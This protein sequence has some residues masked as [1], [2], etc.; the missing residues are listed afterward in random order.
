MGDN[1]TAAARGYAAVAWNPANLALPGN[2]GWSLS[3]AAVRGIAGIDPVTLADLKEYEGELVPSSVRTQWLNAI[4][5]EG[6]EAGSSGFDASWFALQVG[7]FAL[8]FSSSGRAQTELSPGVAELFLFGNAD[9]NGTARDLDL[10][11]SSMDI[12]AYSTGAASYAYPFVLGDGSTR[13]AVGITAKY[14]VGHFMAHGQESTGRATADPLAMQLRFPV[15]HTQFEDTLGGAEPNNGSGLGLDVGVSVATGAW[16]F[17]ATVQN[18]VNSFAWDESLLRFRA[19]TVLFDSEERDADF[20]SQAWTDATGVPDELRTAIDEQKFKPV[21]AA[22]AAGRLTSALRVSADLRL[23]S[24]EGIRV[25]P[26]AHAGAGLEYRVLPFLP[27]RAGAAF[28][29]VDSENSGL[30]LGGGLGIEVGPLNLS[31]A[32]AQRSTDLGKDTLFMVSLLAFGM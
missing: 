13:L 26:K 6:G 3:V 1:Y 20:E 4:R 23:G 27:L 8:Q 24:D 32:V 21:L 7:R 9:E 22:G 10:S 30:Q 18:L 2:P 14:T 29:Q 11:G 15:V 5:E 12:A 17:A 16:T 25:G 19:G 28:V 31:A